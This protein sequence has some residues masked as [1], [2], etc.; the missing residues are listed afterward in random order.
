MQGDDVDHFL[1]MY[2]MKVFHNIASSS[3]PVLTISAFHH[4]HLVSPLLLGVL[5]RVVSFTMGQPL[6]SLVKAV[7]S[8]RS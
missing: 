1:R 4:H 3:D 2:N 8:I 5:S 7:M 6:K